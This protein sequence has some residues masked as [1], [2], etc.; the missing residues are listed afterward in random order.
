[1][2]KDKVIEVAAVG[3]IVYLVYNFG[4]GLLDKLGI[5]TPKNVTNAKTTISPFSPAFYNTIKSGHVFTAAQASILA[6]HVNDGLSA[7]WF[8]DFSEIKAAF[9]S[10]TSKLKV[11][12]V[13]IYYVQHFNKAMLDDL[14]SYL[15][16]EQLSELVTYVNNLPVTD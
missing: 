4:S 16:N 8:N 15:D 14:S 13:A 2:D 3:G 10:M 1:M 7:I 9:D 6:N 12:Q 5:T 11:S